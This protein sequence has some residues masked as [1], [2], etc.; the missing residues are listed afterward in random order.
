MDGDIFNRLVRQIMKY[1]TK[2]PDSRDGHDQKY[3]ISDALKAASGV[4]FFLFPPVSQFM[5]AT[6]EE[7]KRNNTGSLLKIEKLPGD[8]QTRTLLDGTDPKYISPVFSATLKTADSKGIIDNYRVP[9]NHVLIALGGVW[10]H[11]PEKVHRGHC[12]RK[13][14]DGVTTYYHGAMAGAIVK[15]RRYVLPVTGEMITNSDGEKKQDCETDAGKRRVEKH[16]EE[17][18][19]LDPIVLA[20]DLYSHEPF[21]R[22]TLEK[23]MGFLLTCKP[24]TRKRLAETANNSVSEEKTKE[25]IIKGK[26]MRHTYRYINGVPPRYEEKEAENFT[27]NYA[28]FEIKDVK[29]GKTSYKS[30]RITNLRINDGNAEQIVECARTR[31]KIENGHNNVLKNRGYSLK[32][33]FGHGKEHASEIFF[34]LNLPAFQFHTIL[35]CA[36]ENYRKP[37]ARFSVRTVFFETMRVFLYVSFYGSWQDFLEAIDNPSKTYND[38]G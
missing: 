37:G 16:G 12:S 18:L 14:K 8:T 19:R 23:K 9:G 29:T 17:Y 7:Q 31:R 13:T 3:E 27:V 26:R 22:Q 15:P 4:F 10:C 25:I 32:H 11:S 24:A 1:G 20:G 21:C 30:S 38:S 2:V 5:R 6:R 34:L 36:D 33:N 28:D 35:E